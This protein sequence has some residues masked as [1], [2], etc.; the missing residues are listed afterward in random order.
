MELIWDRVFDEKGMTLLSSFNT[1]DIREAE[2]VA[3]TMYLNEAM[4]ST[5]NAPLLGPLG[6]VYHE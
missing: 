4:T 1:V 3:A 2:C 5:L 6:S